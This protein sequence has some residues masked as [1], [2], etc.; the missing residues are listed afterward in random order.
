MTVAEW[1]QLT[2]RISDL[3]P[4]AMTQGA[5]G[6]YFDELEPFGR[7]EVLAAIRALAK[8]TTTKGRPAVGAIYDL[9]QA[10]V[11]QRSGRDEKRHVPAS[12]VLSAA[13]HRFELAAIRRP[14]TAEHRRRVAAVLSTGKRFPLSQ[15]SELLP[16]T[17][18]GPEEFDRR[19]AAWAPTA[20]TKMR[21]EPPA[22]D[23]RPRPGRLHDPE[24]V[25]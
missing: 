11:A 8:S 21:P 22:Q 25:W 1:K 12:D 19:L 24:D 7:D 3:W 20:P 6:A 10:Q 13:Q 17:A 15:L 5:I 14:Q 16:E 2:D 23:R 9:C 18:C 4:P